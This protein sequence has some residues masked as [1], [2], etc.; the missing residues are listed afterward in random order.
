MHTQRCHPYRSE[1]VWSCP[2]HEYCEGGSCRGTSTFQSRVQGRIGVQDLPSQLAVGDA[3]NLRL[4]AI[5]VLAV[6]V[7]TS[8]ATRLIAEGVQL[9]SG[10]LRLMLE[11]TEFSILAMP[12]KMPMVAHLFTSVPHAVFQ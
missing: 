11:L 2:C 3:E 8:K 7:F 6:P 4:T 10:E 9:A 1:H 12:A 5:N